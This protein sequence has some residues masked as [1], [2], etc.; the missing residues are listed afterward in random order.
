MHQ[1]AHIYGFV[2]CIYTILD[3]IY[4]FFY[5]FEKLYFFYVKG[6]NFYLRKL[7]FP[8]HRSLNL[9]KINQNYESNE[10]LNILNNYYK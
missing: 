8:S 2:S 6:V 1:G 5:V 3:Y 7:Y 4:N 9:E 10:I